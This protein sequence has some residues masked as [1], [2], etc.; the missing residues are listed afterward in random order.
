[1]ITPHLLTREE[2]IEQLIGRSHDRPTF[3]FKH[4]LICPMSSS[5]WHRFLS[6]VN[7]EAERVWHASHGSITEESLAEALERISE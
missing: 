1:M 3:L 4:S 2:E 5:A 7:E 6:F